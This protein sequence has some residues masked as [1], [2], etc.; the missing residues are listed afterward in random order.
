[1]RIIR[2]LALAREAHLKAFAFA[3]G[4]P[5]VNENCPACFEAPKE[6][7]RVQKLLLQASPLKPRCISPSFASCLRS[8]YRTV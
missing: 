8:S 3:A 5:V 7:A 1:M 4:L 2:P 6:R